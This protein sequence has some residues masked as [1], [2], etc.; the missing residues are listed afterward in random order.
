MNARV[1]VV[2]GRECPWWFTAG[3]CRNTFLLL[4]CQSI[5]WPHTHTASEARRV[6]TCAQ[7]A[8][9]RPIAATNTKERMGSFEEAE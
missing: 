1:C 4:L 6:R 7:V 3:P 8:K 9:A 5:G 2:R